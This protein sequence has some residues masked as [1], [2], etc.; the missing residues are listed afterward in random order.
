MIKDTCCRDI[1]K[2]E[3]W[4]D[5]GAALIYGYLVLTV[6]ITL[7]AGF[8]LLTVSENLQARR[9]RYSETA[10][11]LAELGINRFLRDSSML[12]DYP[13][14]RT[15]AVGAYQVVMSKDDS[16]AACRIVTSTGIAGGISRALQV[17]FPGNTPVVFGN[18]VSSGGNLNL[19]VCWPNW[20]C[21][22]RPA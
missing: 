12:N 21:T 18:T 3:R 14:G 4:N 5:T 13:S 11:W 7:T 10:F 15:I 6:I 16:D 9:Y 19:W 20:K 2:R 22:A 1:F 17:E 8:T